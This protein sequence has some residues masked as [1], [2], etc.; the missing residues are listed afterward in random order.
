MFFFFYNLWKV[1]CFIDILVK[2]MKSFDYQLNKYTAS[3]HYTRHNCTI[4]CLFQNKS[5]KENLC[6]HACPIILLD[7]SNKII[8]IISINTPPRG[9]QSSLI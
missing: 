1:Q 2:V 3:K 5:L 7:N 6:S 4:V 9:L 8:N